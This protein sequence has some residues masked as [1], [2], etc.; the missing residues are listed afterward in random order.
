MRTPCVLLSPLQHLWS[1]SDH[2]PDNSNVKSDFS[3]ATVAS[4]NSK[5]VSFICYFLLCIIILS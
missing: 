4:M 1:L 5:H 2:T 3:V